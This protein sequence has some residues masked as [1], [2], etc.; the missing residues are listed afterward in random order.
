MMNSNQIISRFHNNH[1]ANVI[2]QEDGSVAYRITGFDNATVFSE[3]HLHPGEFFV[4]E[5]EEN[6]RGWSGYLRLG[7]TQVNPAIFS[8]R[9][10]EFPRDALPDLMRLGK[11]WMYAFTGLSPNFDNDQKISWPFDIGADKINVSNEYIGTCRGNYSRVD[12]R[13]PI[14]NSRT[15]YFE[16]EV[17]SKVGVVY[18]PIDEINANLYYV[19]NGDISGP[20]AMEIPY[21]EGPLFAV[22]DVYGKT[23]KVRLLQIQAGKTKVVKL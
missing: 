23:K 17:G 14:T 20:Y 21:R 18:I 2:L 5:I 22:V 19:I 10:A 1:G 12:L 3:K 13:N 15:R 7:L 9:N 8:S 11:T 16:P 6:V 4:V